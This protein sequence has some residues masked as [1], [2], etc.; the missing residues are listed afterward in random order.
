VTPPQVI[1]SEQ[2]Q[3]EDHSGLVNQA[4]RSLKW[5]FLYNIIPRCVTPFS[6]LI[7][8]GLL[9]P[10]DF[11][12]VAISTFIIALSRILVD[13]GFSKAVIQRKSQVDE[14]AS[15]S[16]W[17]SLLVSI[18]LYI[19]L[20]ITA[21]VISVAY[22]NNEVASVIRVAALSLPLYGF[23]AV[24]KA[25]L[26]RSMEFRNLFW[27][28]TS[29]LIVQ[30]ISSVFLAIAGLG[31]WSMIL[32]QIIG[33]GLSVG[34]AWWFV[35]W[36]PGWITDW[37]MLRP[38]LK[39]SIWVLIS[40]IQN[41]MF[42]YADNAIAG[43]FLGVE[44]LGIYALGFNIAIIIPGLIESSMGDVA[45]PSFCKIQD[46]P[47]QVGENLVKLQGMIGAVLF[48]IVFGFAAI[49][50]PVVNLLYGQKWEGLGNVIALL[51]IMPG[52]ACIWSLNENAYQ[53]V[54]RP[55][56]WT[57][58]AG[59]SLLALL[60]ML[61]IAAPYGLLIFTIVRFLGGWILPIGNMTYGASRLGI[62]LK[63]QISSFASSLPF[64]LLMY[65]LVLL[66]VR[67]M[68]PFVGLLGWVKLLSLISLGAVIYL[69]LLWLVNRTLWN[70]L[71]H[72]LRRVL[73]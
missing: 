73:S 60:P 51:I 21:P 49:A 63:T 36:H 62:G 67:V 27:V 26:R 37:S 15:M 56:I 55:D 5:S 30:A 66:M 14:A 7:L 12:L 44:S 68:N 48:P 8:A 70:E 24:P 59:F 50:L 3:V 38:I 34:L 17:I 57:K 54:G 42:L 46:N 10:A 23:A 71:V 20:W 53:A 16:L 13:L 4:A 6:T 29:F 1:A 18:S 19:L 52:L 43:L 11:G 33:L 35:H 22:H 31:Y 40:S 25:L 61:F 28:N 72:N 9:T 41:W 65:I 58:L 45:Y 2:I 47:H 39:F 32:G 64:A 69:F